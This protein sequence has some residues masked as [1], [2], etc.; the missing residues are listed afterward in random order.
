MDTIWILGDQLSP[1][2][3]ALARSDPGSARVLMVESKARGSMLRYHQVKLVLV[4]SAM[5]H[6]AQELRE[7]GLAGGLSFPGRGPQLRDRRARKHLAAHRPERFILAQPNSFFE[8]EALTRLG[9]K[10]NVPVEFV[11]TAQFLVSRE[12]FA[13]WAGGQSGC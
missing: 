11:P 4:Y 12:E 8:T 13:Q 3:A 9:R 6:F 10:L 7:R 5:R 1:E 2:H